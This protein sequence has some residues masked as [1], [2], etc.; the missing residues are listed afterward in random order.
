MRIAE[1][2]GV[3]ACCV[4]LLM[5]LTT[6]CNET[7]EPQEPG[8]LSMTWRV[9][10]LGCEAAGVLS[11]EVEL[12]GEL[13]EKLSCD[14]GQLIIEGLTPG[15]HAI[16]LH[17]LDSSGVVIFES[18]EQAVGI[19]PGDVTTLND[20]RLTAKP[21]ILQLS[22]H[23]SNGRLCS[24]NNIKDVQVDVYDSDSFPID[25]RVERCDDAM[26]VIEG[27]TS[28]D[29]VVELR[30]VSPAGRV[31]FRGL[32]RLRVK[33]GDVLSRDVAL[34]SCEEEVCD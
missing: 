27:L 2:R 17:G 29:F 8:T 13:I 30:A 33:R 3:G 28:G 25:T 20:V 34:V 11:V 1:Q 15:A 4:L 12:N 5:A 24:A 22:W 10:P 26:T 16:N 18:G 19:A 23:F 7:P 21:G 9:S 14:S 32:E 6:A 31:A